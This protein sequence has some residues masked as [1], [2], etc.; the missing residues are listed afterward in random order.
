MFNLPYALVL[1]SWTGRTRALATFADPNDLW[2]FYTVWREQ[3]EADTL[4]DA[5]FEVC[6]RS[7]RSACPQ[8]TKEEALAWAFAR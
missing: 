5:R 4:R 6:G 8:R 7:I 2:D 1:C 3:V